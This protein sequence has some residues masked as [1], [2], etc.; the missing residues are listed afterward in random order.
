LDKDS[1]AVSKVK[2]AI[3][4]Y[5]N[6]RLE[7]LSMMTKFTHTGV[8]EN[9]FS[10]Q[11][12]YAPKRIFFSHPSMLCKNAL[13]AIDHNMNTDRAQGKTAA[14]VLQFDLVTGRD[15]SKYYVKPKPEPKDMSWKDSIVSVTLKAFVERKIPASRLPLGEE[16]KTRKKS[17]VKPD[18]CTA[19]N[20]HQTRMKMN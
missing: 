15:G 2:A 10:L 1:L 5:K 18:K 13:A 9:L 20:Q 19:I 7:D 3:R 17:A 11:G 4:G 14:G 12:K 16:M 6:S 8:V